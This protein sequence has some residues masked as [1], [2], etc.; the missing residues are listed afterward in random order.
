M[1]KKVSEL[2]N[3]FEEIKQNS[4]KNDRK[5]EKLRA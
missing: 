2:C 4:D 3:R 5:Y 1:K